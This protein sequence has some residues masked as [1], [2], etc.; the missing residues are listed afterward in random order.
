MKEIHGQLAAFRWLDQAYLHA[1]PNHYTWLVPL[2]EAIFPL[3]LLAAMLAP[4]TINWRGHVMQVEHGGGFH[5]VQRRANS[6]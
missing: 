1:T 2:V 4:Q 3:Q 6:G 5:F